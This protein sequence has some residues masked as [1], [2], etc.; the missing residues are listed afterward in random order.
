M[1]LIILELSLTQIVIKYIQYFFKINHL[2]Y[3][4]LFCIYFPGNKVP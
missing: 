4:L 2:N 3:M 1:H